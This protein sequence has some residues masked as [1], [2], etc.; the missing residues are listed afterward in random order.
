[1]IWGGIGC[2]LGFVGTTVVGGGNLGPLLGI[3]VTGPL[4]TLAGA[5]FGIIR[6]TQKAEGR[7]IRPE[8]RWLGIVWVLTLLYVAGSLVLPSIWLAVTPQALVLLT[9]AFLLWKGEARHKLPVLWRRCGPVA[10][11]A[12][13]MIL[14]LTVFPPITRPWW[15]APRDEARTRAAFPDGI[16]RRAA[17]TNPHFDASRRVPD[18]AV[19]RSQLLV[20]WLVVGV[21]AATVTVVIARTPGG[22]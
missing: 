6:S 1:M 17:L 10:L 5:L 8:L 7:S 3:L 9:T 19:D 2:A 14:L 13:L 20:E 11:A 16:P 21:V 18:F 15:Q 22:S 12:G 4:G